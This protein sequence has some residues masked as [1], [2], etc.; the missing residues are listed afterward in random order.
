MKLQLAE[1]L[2]HQIQQGYLS[3]VNKTMLQEMLASVPLVLANAAEKHGVMLSPQD[4]R[5]L[6]GGIDYMRRG[7]LYAMQHP[8][9]AN[10]TSLAQVGEPYSAGKPW[11]DG[12][13]KYCFSPDFPAIGR[14]VF[15]LAVQ[16]ITNY[17]SGPSFVEIGHVSGNSYSD[18]ALMKCA[19]VP[20]LFVRS[21]AGQGC[22]AYMGQD[23]WHEQNGYSQSFQLE[24]GGCMFPG[25]AVHELCHAL[26]MAHEQSRPDR[27]GYIRLNWGNIQ[28]GMK[29]AYDIHPNGFI[30]WPYDYLSI[31]HY[32]GQDPIPFVYDDSI[33]SFTKLDGSTKGLGQHHGLRD[34]DIY[35]LALMYGGSPRYNAQDL[36]AYDLDTNCPRLAELGYCYDNIWMHMN[37][38]KSCNR[39]VEKGGDWVGH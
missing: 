15:N 25:V 27:D 32:S 33:P 19:E 16:H 13:V 2:K 14:Q 11:V 3:K 28:P 6:N 5:D 21:A 22:N 24:D 38:L 1:N 9:T 34:S 17:V 30:G 4:I 36:C 23:A 37:C 26:A 7:D 18:P 31:M 35:Q 8:V 39:C 29:F 12:I 10:A 20:S